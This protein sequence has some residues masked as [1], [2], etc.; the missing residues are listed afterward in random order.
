MIMKLTTIKKA[1][2]QAVRAIFLLD[3]LSASLVSAMKTGVFAIG[4]IIAKNPIKAPREYVNKL[5]CKGFG[6][7]QL[8]YKRKLI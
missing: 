8:K 7:K 3:S 4:F 2:I 6:F 1:V 5:S